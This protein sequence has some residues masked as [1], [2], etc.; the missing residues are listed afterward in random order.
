MLNL[1]R[2]VR[3]MRAAVAVSALLSG[4]VLSGC[5]G[6]GGSTPPATPSGF[7]SSPQGVVQ[8]GLTADNSA[9]SAGQTATFT[10][11]QQVSVSNPTDVDEIMQVPFAMD[12]V[13]ARNGQT[14]WQA[15]RVGPT[16]KLVKIF[17]T[18]QRGD[19]LITQFK[20]DLKDQQGNALPAGQYTVTGWNNLAS[21]GGAAITDPETQAA[22]K[23]ITITLQ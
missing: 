9:Y 20:W 1:L 5:G 6:G 22:A 7:F 3:A 23:P 10:V 21:I 15:S 8:F 19:P 16:Q 17:T 4:A 11:S 18:L 13:V 14:V 2:R 12:V